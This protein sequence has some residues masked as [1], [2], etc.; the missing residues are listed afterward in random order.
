MAPGVNP[1]KSDDVPVWVEL[2]LRYRFEKGDMTFDTKMPCVIVLNVTNKSRRGR[3][4][5]LFT[6]DEAKCKRDGICVAECPAKIIQLKDEDGVPTPVKGADEFCIQCGHC[7]AVCPH[8]A[9]SHQSMSPEQCPPVKREWILDPEKVEHFLRSRRSIRTY[10]E[11]PVDREI[12]AKLIDIARYA[13][14]GHNLQPVQWMVI[15][16]HERVQELAGMVVDWMRFMIKEQ[17]AMAAAMNLDKVVAAWEMGMDNVCRNAPHIILAHAPKEDR[18]ALT[19]CT[20][21]LTYLELAVPSFGLGACWA[22][23]FGAAAAFWPPMQESL[24]L[25]EGH[26]CFGAM[27]V[28]YPKYRYHRL[29]LRNDPQIIWSS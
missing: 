3:R 22:G 5:T 13:P 23:F 17:P 21:A 9:L 26:T 11:D 19:A 14:S 1:L 24:G 10:K 20:I 28:G 18:T 2:F 12:I 8:G 29:P 15:Y 16:D 25:P 6:V 27:M 7:V 4:M